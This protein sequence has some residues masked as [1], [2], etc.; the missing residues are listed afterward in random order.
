MFKIS[1]ITKRKWFSFVRNIFK[2]INFHIYYYKETN[3][4][5]NIEVD[6]IIDVG[7]AH[8]T[9]FLLENFP[10][11]KFFLI[12]PNPFF[13]N[14]IEKNI[15]EKYNGKLFKVAVGNET[16]KKKFWH[17]DDA[18]YI[19]SFIQRD[20]YKLKKQIDV[21]VAKL[22]D[23]LKDEKLN[24][25]S[26]LKIDTEGYELEVLKGAERTLSKVNCLVIEIRLENIQT[27][28]PSE[29]ISFLFNKNFIFHKIIKVNFYKNGISYIDAIFLKK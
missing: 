15:I 13:F 21:N 20:D 27:Y 3:Y 22:D 6:N 10:K 25:K 28:N 16:C 2:K 14:F 24:S 17:S 1:Y 4:F 9:D 23:I 29:I 8:G 5:K 18:S 11:A 26:L 12:E 7:V 19:S